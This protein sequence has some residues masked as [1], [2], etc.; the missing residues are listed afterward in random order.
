[1]KNL[2]KF[3]SLAIAT[4]LMSCGGGDDNPSTGGTTNPSTP[5]AGK[6]QKNVLIE[7]YTGT[8]CQYCPRVAYGIQ[9]VEAA[10][11]KAFPV[12]IHRGGGSAYDPFNYNAAARKLH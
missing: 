6:F 2:I 5:I 9:L 8:W 7:D 10:N 12:A 1:M 4:L 11:I 3:S